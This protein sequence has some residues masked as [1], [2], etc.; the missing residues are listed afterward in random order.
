MSNREI[1]LAR[2]SDLAQ[3]V[4]IYNQAVEIEATADTEPVAVEQR[5]H[6]FT[7]HASDSYPIWVAERNS[8]IEGWISLSPYRPGRGAL[9]SVA[10][11]SYYVRNDF[12]RQ[13]VG[14][15]L[16]N[17]ALYQSPGLGLRTLFAI[18]L[19]DNTAS[20]GLLRK[21]GF[22]QWAHL[23]GVARFGDR[24]IGQVYF[25]RHLIGQDDKDRR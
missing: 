10:E 6:W 12:K 23:P 2:L 16:M 13:G 19:E 17:H 21:F 9:Q 4:A 5:R 18:L 22:T 25:G 8:T 15:D 1:R 11:I 7:S 14:S 20:I 24:V 3:I